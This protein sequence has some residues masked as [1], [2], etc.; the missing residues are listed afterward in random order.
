[1]FS[2]EPA[3]CLSAGAAQMQ[4]IY[5]SF[6][7]TF[8]KCRT[9]SIQLQPLSFACTVFVLVLSDQYFSSHAVISDHDRTALVSFYMSA[10]TVL[11]PPCVTALLPSGFHICFFSL[12]HFVSISSSSIMCNRLVI[13]LLLLAHIVAGHPGFLLTL[14]TYTIT[15]ESESMCEETAWLSCIM[16]R[17]QL[18]CV[19]MNPKIVNKMYSPPKDLRKSIF[20]AE[21]FFTRNALQQ[22]N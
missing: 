14:A 2:G 12:L 5:Q 17:V 6:I 8:L 4:R 21:L 18:V 11:F 22:P 10:P 1:M 9:D 7:V 15:L 3:G 19:W 20:S 13:T 16:M